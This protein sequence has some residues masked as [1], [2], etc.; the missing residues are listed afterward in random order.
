MLQHLEQRYRKIFSIGE[1]EQSLLLQWFFGAMLFFF[2]LSFSRFIGDSSTTIEVAQRGAAI[3]WPYFQDCARWYFLS[4]L[5][6]GYTQSF[7]YMV[8]YGIMLSIVYFIWKKA[9]VRAHV[10]MGMLL[11]W[12]L[13]VI[14]LLSYLIAGPYDYYHVILTSVLL[15]VPFKEYF[16]KL[17]FVFLYFMSVTPK[18]D[19]TWVLGSY[20]TS[21][22]TGLPIFPTALTPLFTNL[23]IASQVVGCWFLLSR[24]KMVQRS[25]VVFFAFFHLYSGIF[26]YYTYP[27]IALFPLLILFGPLYAY[28][29]TPF[30]KK[31]FAGVLLLGFV[32]LFQA[33]GFVTDTDRRVTLEGNR[34]GMFMFEANHQCSATVST[35]SNES[36]TASSTFD[37]LS[38][39]GLYCLT[40]V[41]M[42]PDHGQTVRQSRYESPSAWNRCDP[43]EWWAKLHTQCARNPLISRIAFQFDHS[44]NGGPF[45][46]IVDVPNMCDV[47]YKPFV[48]NEW[49]KLPGEAQV[50][51][52]PVQNIYSY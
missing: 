39:S 1:I 34:Y 49:I 5:P 45:Y 51:G 8:L 13:I 26:V 15:L 42:F 7:F 17:S 30:S 46:R 22:V 14:F 9:W 6:Y 4:N 3:C 44:I 47:S 33:L 35:Y 20:F 50:V 18:F 27:T 23:V 28:T 32:A 29:P 12:K 36:T 48:H 25:A 16:L 11:V 19:A 41:S 31:A 37:T 43:Y 24:H 2:F 52:H 38:C 40:R 21:L 10:L